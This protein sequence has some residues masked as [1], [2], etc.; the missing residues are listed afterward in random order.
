LPLPERITVTSGDD[1]SR[2]PTAHTCAPISLVIQPYLS[3]DDACAK[4]L[5]AMAHANE[6]SFV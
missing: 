4:F 3:T 5:S 2:Y 1:P 6:F